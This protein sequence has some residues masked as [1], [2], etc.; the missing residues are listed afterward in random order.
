MV[1]VVVAVVAA[2]AYSK[3]QT[4][5]VPVDGADPDQHHPARPASRSTPVT[6]PDPVQALGST[7]VQL[8]AAKLLGDPDV[9]AVAGPGDRHGRPD[10]RGPDHH[11]HRAPTP[12]EAQAVAKAYSQAYVDQIQALVQAQIDKITTALDRPRRQD[13]RTCEAQPLQP[14]ADHRPDRPPSTRPPA[15]C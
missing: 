4:P 1:S 15:R 13:R 10:H 8:Q 11:R 9:S 2:L 12:K 7:A 3:L 6:L 14:A 5:D